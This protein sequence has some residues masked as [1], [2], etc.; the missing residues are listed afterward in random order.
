MPCALLMSH[1]IENGLKDALLPRLTEVALP[2]EPYLL[3]W[4]MTMDRVHDQSTLTLAALRTA[5]AR[6][7]Y[8]VK[9]NDYQGLEV[10]D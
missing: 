6:S 4:T 8:C 7:A 2:C 9:S 1:Q 3:R 10:L 5:N